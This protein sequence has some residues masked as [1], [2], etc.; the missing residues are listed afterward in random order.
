MSSLDIHG[1]VVF[2]DPDICE[3]V[4]SMLRDAHIA[5][6]VA[7]A[8]DEAIRV[9]DNMVAFRRP[10]DLVLTELVLPGK[11]G[12]EI[13][14]RVRNAH[15]DEALAGG[16]RLRHI[17]VILT[18]SH[19]QSDYRLDEA[20][21]L[22]AAYIEMPF[23]VEP[24]LKLIS[25]CLSNYRHAIL[26]DFQR[27]GRALFWKEG[28]FQVAHT[29]R[30]RAAE[31]KYWS[32]LMTPDTLGR[33]AKLVMMC[34]GWLFA[35]S[36]V[37]EFEYLLNQPK[38]T[39][40]NLQ[41]F[42]K[43][44]PEFLDREHDSYWSEPLLKSIAGSSIIRPD[45]VLQRRGQRELPWT[46]KIVDLK[47]PRSRLMSNQRFHPTLS[48]EVYHLKRQLEDYGRF[49]EDPTNAELLKR[50]FGGVVPRPQLA[51]LIGRVPS[52]QFE[53][54]SDLRKDLAGVTIATYDEILETRREHVTWMR[55]LLGD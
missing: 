34:E 43:Q 39:E 9:L 48:S 16:F 25:T 21:A 53:R 45:F 38:T 18:S 7:R 28:R 2:N 15:D 24:L 8:G 36:A 6:T 10:L 51:G 26:E 5:V 33:Y 37:S 11:S 41:A 32:G 30:P 12:I 49:F 47:R 31:G 19:L 29:L 22:H 35:D 27:S 52:G 1:L 20:A 55:K 46:W 13:I 50:K 40:R 44:H 42:F 23:T 3:L 17:P 14:K 54:F 4:E